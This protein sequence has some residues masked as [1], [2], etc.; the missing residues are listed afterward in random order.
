MWPGRRAGP[1]LL[2]VNPSDDIDDV[3]RR[4]GVMVRRRWIPEEEIQARLEQIAAD[5]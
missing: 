4:A 3:R 2:Q 1:T 5:S